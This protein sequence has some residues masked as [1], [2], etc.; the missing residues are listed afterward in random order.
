MKSHRFQEIFDE[1]FRSD[2]WWEFENLSRIPIFQQHYRT[3]AQEI[4]RRSSQLDCRY[5]VR[6]MLKTH[7]FCACSFNLAQFEDW[8]MLAEKLS[9]TVNRGRSAYR[10]SLVLLR[11]TILPLLEQF[12]AKTNA[13]DL[14]ESGRR[15]IEIFRD[16]SN[17][18][19]LKNGE[20]IVLQKILENLPVAPLLHLKMPEQDF[21]TREE[22][23]EK[24]NE[25]V[26]ELPNEPVLLK[27]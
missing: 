12:S 27:I 20:L 10:R 8:E 5:N 19:L 15:L 4:R 26:G 2:E 21:M 1:I 23:S 14:A 7:P 11:E 24:F 22:M 13:H 3:E 17:F 6:E 18:P 16:G 9:E 25:W